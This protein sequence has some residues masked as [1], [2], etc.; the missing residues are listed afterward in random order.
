MSHILTIDIG[1]TSVKVG[2][3]D[4]KM[5]PVAFHIQEYMLMTP[6]KDYVELEPNIYWQAIKEAILQV[7]SK[8]CESRNTIMAIGITSQGET[9]I[10][11][12]SMGK[13]LYNAIVWLDARANMEVVELS[14]VMNN[15][16]FYCATGMKEFGPATPLCKLLWFKNNCKTIYEQTEKFL[17]LSD[18]VAFLFTGLITTEKT[19]MSSTGYYD[20]FKRCIWN[21][22][23]IKA[24]LDPEKIPD[25]KESGSEIGRILPSVAEELGLTSGVRIIVAANDQMCSA[26]GGGNITP[27]IVTE[28]TGTCLVVSTTIDANAINQRSSLEYNLHVYDKYLIFNLAKTAGI[29]LKWFKDEFFSNEKKRYYRMGKDIYEL[30]NQM[31]ESIP[32]GSCGLMLYPYFAGKLT[33]QNQPEAKGVFFNVGLESTKA[34]FIR[35]LFEGV[36]FM[37]KENLDFI[38]KNGIPIKI[39]RSLGGGSRSAVWNQIKADVLNKSITVLQYEETTSLGAAILTAISSGWFSTLEEACSYCV[40]PKKTF[41]PDAKGVEFYKQAYN[42]YTELDKSMRTLY[43][44]LNKL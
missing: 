4:R 42:S 8:S 13:A 15:E 28:T 36:A 40:I 38:E 11:V 32:Q 25:V 27:G 20:I 12:D 37:L 43:A 14:G 16:Q 39:I 17:L 6:S 41:Y 33:P 21:E 34:H 9:L 1:T 29:I 23:L 18:Y 7:L 10:P 44:N 2:L 5:K 22:G 3:F 31:A 35:A 26:V 19:M 30:M 24:G